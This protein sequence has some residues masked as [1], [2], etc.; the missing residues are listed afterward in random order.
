VPGRSEERAHR[1]VLLYDAECR[2]CRFAARVIVRVD[3]DREL[4]ILP[5]LDPAAGPLLATLGDA[6]RLASWRLTRAGAGAA[7]T[8][9]GAGVPGL[10]LAMRRTRWLGRLAQS[11]PAP[12]L[13]A[14]YGLVA[15]NRGR[16]G[17]VVPDGRAPRRY[18]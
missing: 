9:Y 5:L 17:R 6:E 1:P 11:V 10:L 18:P 2:V 15:R 3:R 16:L 4:A 12:V 13:D 7:P 14:A 8:G